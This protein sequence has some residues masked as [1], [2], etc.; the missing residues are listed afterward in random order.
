VGSSM[1][2]AR[3]SILNLARG[4]YMLERS[5]SEIGRNAWGVSDVLSMWGTPDNYSYNNSQICDTVYN[6]VKSSLLFHI[7]TVS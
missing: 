6:S 7:E 1:I 4:N 3:I 5:N 2:S